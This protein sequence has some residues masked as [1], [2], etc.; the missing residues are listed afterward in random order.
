MLESFS[1]YTRGR[2]QLEAVTGTKFH[3]NVA[4]MKYKLAGH[5]ILRHEW[6]SA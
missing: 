3:W 1:Y 4:K 6:D 5:H 2:T